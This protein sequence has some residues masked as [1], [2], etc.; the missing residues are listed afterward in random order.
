M[1]KI[2]EQIKKELHIANRRLERYKK[3][4]DQ[5]DEL[6]SQNKLSDAGQLDLVYVHTTISRTLDV[7]DMLNDLLAIDDYG[8]FINESTNTR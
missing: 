1:S 3:K 2:K 5:L 6:N 7:I 4:Y 8:D